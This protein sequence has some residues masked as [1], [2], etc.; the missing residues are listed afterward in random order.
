[1]A[2]KFLYAIA[3]LTVLVIAALFAMRIWSDDLTE[4]AFVPKAEFTPQPEVSDNAYR[5]MDMWIARPGMGSGNPVEWLPQGFPGEDG[6]GLNVAL[7]FVHP[8]SYM[9]RAHWNA[10]LDEKVSR[11][12]AEL[13]VRGMG[14]AF[15]RTPDIWAPRYRQAAF[16]AFLTD[17]PEGRQAID[18][19]YKDVEHAF[20]LFAATVSRKSLIVLA[21]HSQGAFHL[22]RLMQERV[23]G[24]PLAA[25]IA[26][27]YA[28]GWPVSVE[29]DLPAM[30][31][32]AC[33]RPDQS[34]CVVSWLSFAEP[35]D[36]GLLLKQYGR[37]PGLDGNKPLEGSKFVCTNPLTGGAPGIAPAGANL[38]TL[39]PGADLKG[40]KLVPGMV[41][42]ACRKDGI[43]SIG[44][45][46]EMGPYVL[47]GNNYHLY[48]I[49]LFWMNLRADFTRRTLAWRPRP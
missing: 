48:D 39:L 1:M 21:G 29:H 13:F 16:G 2:R 3:A 20:D 33:L 10:P 34:G 40:G 46:P 6:P 47:P 23:A 49:P 18:L 27:V 32:P 8:T 19:A 43:L 28:I 42:A 37:Q 9:E 44:A 5:A 30:G 35:A 22:R 25:R 41:G 7:F 38:G 17:K 11:Q 24:T 26:A 45:P 36:T 15:N 31:L 14:S 12:R 4:M